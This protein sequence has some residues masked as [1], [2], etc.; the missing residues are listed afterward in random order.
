MTKTKGGS[1]ICTSVVPCLSDGLAKNSKVM[2]M[3]VLFLLL[4][5]H[6][7]SFENEGTNLTP[8]Q[9]NSMFSE[10]LKGT[11]IKHQLFK[12]LWLF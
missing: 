10:F 1:V 11:T 6:F 8:K 9:S 12:K 7:E 3:L 5:C 4:F 2:F